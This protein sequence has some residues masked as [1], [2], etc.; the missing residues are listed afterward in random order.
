MSGGPWERYQVTQPDLPPPVAQPVPARDAAPWEGYRVGPT[1]AKP[2][3]RSTWNMLD[4]VV[5]QFAAGASMYTA[6]EIAAAGDTLL[7]R[8]FAPDTAGGYAEAIPYADILKMHRDKDKAFVS[9]YPVTSGIAQA[10]GALALLPAAIPKVL[11]GGGKTLLGTALRGA[12]G[13]AALGGASG[14]GQGEGSFEDRA[15]SAGYGAAVGGGAGALLPPVIATGG[16]IAKPLGGRWMQENVGAPVLDKLADITGYLTPKTKPGAGTL[17]AAAPDGGIPMAGVM[18]D[19]T[20]ALR[21]KATAMANPA[22]TD[23]MKA[24]ARTMAA[25]GRSTED[26][27]RELTL[28]GPEAMLA[29]ASPI[30]TQN[31]LRTAY[32]SPGGAM[33][34]I[35]DALNAQQAAT[36]RMMTRAFEGPTPPPNVY[37]ATRFLKGPPEGAPGPRFPGYISTEG[38]RLY[39]PLRGAP[40]DEIKISPAMREM[41][42]T[43]PAVREAYEN[44][45]ASAAHTG[46]KLSPFDVLHRVKQQLN[47][48]ADRA[49]SAPNGRAINKADVNKLADRWERELY[50]ANRPIQEADQSYAALKSLTDWLE[51]GR[52]FMRGGVNEVADS[53]SPAALAAEFPMATAAQQQLFRVGATGTVSD[54]ALAGDA[55]TR[56]LARNINSSEPLQEKLGT[57]FPDQAPAIRDTSR[58]VESFAD[59]SN[60]VRRNSQTAAVLADQAE[61]GVPTIMRGGG[62]LT[63]RAFDWGSDKVRALIQNNEA[64]RDAYTRVLLETNPVAN[65]Q[66]L[67][68]LDALI[69]AQLQGSAARTG[70]ADVAGG[71]G[72]DMLRVWR[73][74]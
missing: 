1:P 53:V 40:A 31:L 35:E 33:Q 6:D 50:A 67:E 30:Q 17:S 46:E 42:D 20:N 54:A 45:Q 38:E 58:A 12:A 48:D 72:G 16:A 66:A 51:R 11:W 74:P 60:R 25:G 65:A 69:R 32:M 27:A 24:I 41:I 43:I 68:R 5:R 44:V 9:E 63:S 52:T 3:P 14:F 61:Q 71:Q 56:R 15:R 13:G 4:N 70:A 34:Q 37:D 62:T 57:I 7:N 47:A 10:G 26:I 73:T 36:P 19:I 49:M 8:S 2:E 28:M 18:D 29:N 55:A 59:M 23:A 39:G 22:E 64:V 21:G